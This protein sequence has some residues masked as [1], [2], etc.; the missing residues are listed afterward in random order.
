LNKQVDIEYKLV[1]DFCTQ[2]RIMYASTCDR[3]LLL[4]NEIGAGF[5]F[6]LKAESFFVRR[7]KSSG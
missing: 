4:K 3:K 5:L 6:Q 7:R 1:L 2:I